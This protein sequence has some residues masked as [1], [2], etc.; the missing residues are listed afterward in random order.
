[1]IE[2]RDIYEIENELGCKGRERSS[3]TN[4]KYKDSKE[5]SVKRNSN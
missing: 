2:D 5:T 3:R 4:K 1:M